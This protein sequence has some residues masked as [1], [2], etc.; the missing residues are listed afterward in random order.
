MIALLKNKYKTNIKMPV[1]TISCLKIYYIVIV[2]PFIFHS[3]IVL[4]IKT[5]FKMYHT[6]SPPSHIDVQFDTKW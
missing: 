3:I 6:K 4:Y 2:N 5:L 1:V